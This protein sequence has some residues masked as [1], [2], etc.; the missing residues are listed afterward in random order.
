MWFKILLAVFFLR[1][2][3]RVYKKSRPPSLPQRKH[4]ALALAHPFASAVRL[5]TFYAIADWRLSDT[6]R[7]Q[8][9]PQLLHQMGLPTDASGDEARAHLA[10]TLESHWFRADLHDLLPTDDPRAALAFACARTAFLVRAAMMM[11]WVEP[12]AAWRVL[13]LNAQRA[14]D[15]FASW[16]DFGRAFLEGRRQWVGAFRADPFGKTFDEAA[17]SAWL[18]S[19]RNGWRR[20]PW[21]GPAAFSPAPAT[22]IAEAAAKKAGKKSKYALTSSPP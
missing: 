13:L 22:T 4:W 17:L 18:G 11:E 5:R 9:R 12:Q 2:V 1:W 14:Q 6:K 16:E 19:G 20:L 10:S 7:A 21:P 8:F 3:Y 15:C